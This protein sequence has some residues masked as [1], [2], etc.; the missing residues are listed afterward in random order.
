VDIQHLTITWQV[1]PTGAVV[2]LKG[3]IGPA[4]HGDLAALAEIAAYVPSLTIDLGGV[5]AFDEDSLDLLVELSMRSN[6]VLR[7]AGHAIRAEREGFE[8][9]VGCPTPH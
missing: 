6:V 9:S 7:N 4:D 3:R 8:P 5:L 2:D 1:E